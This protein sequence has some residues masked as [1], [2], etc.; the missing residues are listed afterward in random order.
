MNTSDIDRVRYFDYLCAAREKLFGWVRNQPAEVYRRSFPVGL[1][2]ISVTLVHTASVQWGHTQR[3]LGREPADAS[4][5]YTD[6]PFSLDNQPA[7]EQLVTMWTRVNPQ[8]RQA[9]T[10]LGDPHRHFEFFPKVIKPP[11]RIRVTADVLVGH[12]L[13]H[14]VHHRAQVMTMLRQVGV[15]AEN[16]DYAILMGESTLLE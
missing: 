2:S 1:G 5:Q 15:A 4:G 12:M 14:E 13:F 7:F 11:I 9:L 6:N 10:D 8:T 16:L 3:L